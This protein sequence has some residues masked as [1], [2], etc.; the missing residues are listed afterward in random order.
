MGAILAQCLSIKVELYCL[1]LQYREDVTAGDP[2]PDLDVQ[3][4][5]L[6]PEQGDSADDYVSGFIARLW[7]AM[8]VKIPIGY[9]DETGFHL[10]TEFASHQG[11]C[12]R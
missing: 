11:C 2:L 5:K 3:R 4:D 9:E 10:G 12:G 1:H 7:A 6:S 8:I